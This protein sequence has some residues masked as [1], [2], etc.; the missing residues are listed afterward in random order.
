MQQ[1]SSEGFCRQIFRVLNM[2][3]NVQVDSRVFMQKRALRKYFAD[4]GL[5]E[6]VRLD[7][8]Q[9][10]TNGR[11]HHSRSKTTGMAPASANPRASA[12]KTA[13][14]AMS[15][16][17][18]L[19]ATE[20]STQKDGP[21]TCTFACRGKGWHLWTTG[22]PRWCSTRCSRALGHR[23]QRQFFTPFRC[24]LTATASQQ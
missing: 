15:T 17:T 19:A 24:K 14:K 1:T 5:T 13:S 20:P 9:Q 2:D 7:S 11:T 3:A 21:A 4:S 6:V 22:S 18:E 10:S 12:F 23:M 8:R 16:E